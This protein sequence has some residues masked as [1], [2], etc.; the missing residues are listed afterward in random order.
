M[1]LLGIQGPR[2]A[3]PGGDK[4]FP[5]YYAPAPPSHTAGDA[6]PAAPSEG[7]PLEQVSSGRT[8]A[9]SLAA[10]PS[11]S[12]RGVASQSSL[13][14]T[15]STSDMMRRRAESRAR[16]AMEA[17]A[18]DF[19]DVFEGRKDPA[20]VNLARLQALREESIITAAESSSSS[21]GAAASGSDRLGI[22]RR[23]GTMDSEATRRRGLFGGRPRSST[24]AKEGR[25]SLS[26]RGE[27]EKMV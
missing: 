19:G 4:D 5:F 16:A 13:S 8:R 27:V 22:L 14:D 10:A 12:L 26:E 21:V 1:L 7:H 24:A 20:A 6:P 17:Q 18:M 11:R 9:G 2:K 15:R 23:S 3:T 25:A